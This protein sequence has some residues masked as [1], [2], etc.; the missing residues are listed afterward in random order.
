MKFS[1]RSILGLLGVS[2]PMALK[3]MEKVTATKNIFKPFVANNINR[4]PMVQGMT[5]ESQAQFSIAVPQNT[6][7]DFWLT[8]IDGN[9]IYQIEIDE[10]CNPNYASQ[11]VFKFT[12]S[13]LNPATQYKIKILNSGA[14]LD[15]RTFKTLDSAK[16]SLKFGLISC[17]L[18]YLY[19]DACWVNLINEKPDL[20]FIIGDSCYADTNA[21]LIDKQV[22]PVDIWKRNI[23][24][25]KSIRFYLETELIPM[26]SLWDDHDYGKNN[27]GR[28]FIHK[29]ES[30]YIFESFFAQKVKTDNTVHPIAT[31]EVGPG[32]SSCIE[33]LGQRFLLLDGRWF[34]SKSNED[35][36]DYFGQEIENWSVEKLNQSPMPTWI[37]S[38]S[39]WFGGYRKKE[40]FEYEHPNLFTKY[41][42]RLKDTASK[43][44]F[45][46]GDV[47]F[48]ELMQIEKDILGYPTY[49]VVSSNM[50]ST[51]MGGLNERKVNKRRIAVEWQNNFVIIESKSTIN[52]NQHKI[53]AKL[54]CVKSTG[55]TSFEKILE[56]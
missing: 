38:G 41:L 52:S 3:A 37:M 33:I 30:K 35:N 2:L 5:T 8:D 17:T 44:I 18:D 56:V 27:G 29:N 11:P 45:A 14:L 47:H 16:T 24:T 36:P 54:K 53:E 42:G 13:N 19:N 4:W 50:H 9:E 6:T 40:S 10:K 48:T 12:I 51:H 22:T 25:R 34:R 49:E 46:S 23:E 26:I 43:V 1:R 55:L 31:L 39:Q 20:V 28:E 7:P 21:F 32:V 15:T